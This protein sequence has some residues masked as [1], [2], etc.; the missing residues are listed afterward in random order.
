M[1]KI[2][3]LF[4]ACL[5]FIQ[6][7]WGQKRGQELLDSLETRLSIVKNDSVKINILINLSFEYVA[8]NPE[9]GIAFAHQLYAAS[10]KMG[11]KIGESTALM[12]LGLNYTMKSEPAK[13]LEYYFKALA[14]SEEISD[15]KGIAADLANISSLYQEEKRYDEA[16]KYLLKALTVFKQLNEKMSISKVYTNLGVIANEQNKQEEAIAYYKNARSVAEELK[17][18]RAV[19]TNIGNIA[20][21]YSTNKQYSAA[22]AYYFD[23]IRRSRKTG[24]NQ[25]LIV[26]L[27]N[28]SETFIN[29]AN[30]S[31]CLNP[32][33]LIPSTRKEVISKAINC[34]EQ[35]IDVAKQMG[36]KWGLF[37]IYLNLANA[38]ELKGNYKEGLAY[39][40]QSTIYK[41]SIYNT[42]NKQTIKN[43]ED[44]R[45]I[46]LRDKQLQITALELSNQKQA[47]VAEAIQQQQQLKLRQSALD[48]SNK[49]LILTQQEKQFQSL[50][51]E[52]QQGDYM[53][54]QKEKDNQLKLA[55]QQSKI[56]MLEIESSKRSRYLFIAGLLLLAGVAAY[57]MRQNQLR[58]KANQELSLSNRQ[59]D[60]ANRVKARFFGILSH[61]LRAPIANLT[62]YLHLQRE[63]PELMD[64]Q[65][66]AA[67]QLT[68]EHAANNL[69]S[70]MEDL[71]L[72]SKGQMTSFKPDIKSVQILQLF[73]EIKKLVPHDTHT[74]VVFADP[75]LL[76]M[77]TDENFLKTIM[78]NL[79][80]NALKALH[81]HPH[82]KV[83]WKAWEENGKKYLS[84]TDNGPGLS[85]EQLESLFAESAVT[86]SKTGLG[87]HIVRDFAQMLGQQIEVRSELGKGTSFVLTVA[88]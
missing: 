27:M 39:F 9:K 71:L 5:F 73:E 4:L 86:S 35:S 15:K 20:N 6:E 24:N 46:E 75:G 22:I 63:A 25:S 29:I 8:V 83:E 64:E 72:W 33:T 40:K 78:R 34:L 74:D 60:E 57:V 49:Q 12:N 50:A 55:E 42:E 26:N 79:T 82:G 47:A 30:D 41:D 88:A 18:D 19:I 10:G 52:K 44:K 45:E 85:Q 65:S 81:G 77:D 3:L 66:K 2:V 7:G 58:R 48:L 16:I 84:V 68:I 23:A 61:D 54:A 70:V 14:I 37:Q 11:W 59:L 56:Q 80:A 87:L 21:V 38:Y 62:N 31:A 51:F 17:D 28:A 76:Y 67:H 13:A 53:R 1:K 36:Y 32:D 43:L 69:L